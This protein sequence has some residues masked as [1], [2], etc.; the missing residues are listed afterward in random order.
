[1]NHPELSTM[2]AGPSTSASNLTPTARRAVGAGLTFRA[3]TTLV[4]DT[5]RQ[6]IASKLMIL[7][8]G[9]S[10]LGILGCL[11]LRVDGPM[12]L[13]VKG[14]IELVGPD[15]K[16][17]TGSG[18]PLGRMSIGFGLVK[19]PIF[20]D[21]QS[22][23]GF[24]E[25]VIA[26]WAAGV[27]GTLLLLASTAGFLPEFLKPGAASILLAKPVPRWTLLTGKALGV[28]MFVTVLIGGF[29][30]GTWLAI[31]WRTKVWA[32]GYLLAWP[33]LVVQFAGLY[34]ASVVAATCTRNATVSLFTALAC[35]VICL[36]VNHSRDSLSVDEGSPNHTPITR[37]AVEAAYWVLPKPIDFSK[38]L[39]QAVVASDHFAEAT[40]PEADVSGGRVGIALSV[41]SSLA[42]AAVM[43]GVAGRQLSTTD[44]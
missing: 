24:I 25:A 1:M 5:F 2:D 42:F 3:I 4:V 33:L 31:G 41:L 10:A 15:Q 17:L 19:V 23:V 26:R 28:L 40:D 7:A 12:S 44:Y 29:V 14:E 27:A 36:G 32:P 37:M 13:K 11:S 20:R 8:V 16:P 22:E 9:L 21:V 35:W 18:Q 38:M 6:A 34:M 30:V 43:L 39:D